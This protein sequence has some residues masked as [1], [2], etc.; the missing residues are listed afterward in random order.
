[1][2]GDERRDY[3]FK[4]FLLDVAERRLS[5]SDILV[6]LTPKAFDV[7]VYLVARRGHLVRKE[8]LMEA[9]WPGAG[10]RR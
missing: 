7:L 6:P 10:R 2:Y 8:E 9:V 4:S 3:R 1:M 5:N